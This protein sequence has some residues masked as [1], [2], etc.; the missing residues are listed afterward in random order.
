MMAV[1]T[2]GVFKLGY[3]VAIKPDDHVWGPPETYPPFWKINI[4]GMSV[5]DA[6]FYRESIYDTS[7]PDDPVETGFRK[8]KFNPDS[9]PPPIRNTLNR[10]GEITVTAQQV[11]DYFDLIEV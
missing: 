6:E 9:L 2:P 11:I 8:R 10:D 7:N 1:D 5:E 4:T 3:V